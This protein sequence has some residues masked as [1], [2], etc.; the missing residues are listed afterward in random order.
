MNPFVDNLEII[1][2]KF[3]DS[4]Y[5]YSDEVLLRREVDMDKSSSVR[6]YSGVSNRKLLMGLSGRSMKLFVWLGMKL[7]GGSDIIDMG[8]K[9]KR[10]FM[11][12]SGEVSFVRVGVCLRELCSKG[13]LSEIGD[14]SYYI[15][16]SLFFNGDRRRKWPNR[17]VR[18]N[19]LN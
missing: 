4:A 1:C 12:E 5:E 14:G 16:P 15:N 9:R 19:K 17:I 10:L 11:K 6:I 2:Y 13:V 7:E 8:D 3:L 18:K